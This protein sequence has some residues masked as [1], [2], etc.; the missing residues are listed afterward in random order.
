MDISIREQILQRMLTILEP[1]AT[2]NSATLHRS[3]TV[4]LTREQ[5]P[6]LVLFPEAETVVQKANDRLVRELTVKIVALARAVPPQAPETLAD[7]LMT[8]AHRALF[9]DRNLGGLILSL[10][11]ESCDWDVEDADAI[12]AAIPVTYRLTY[13]THQHDIAL[14]G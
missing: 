7:Q 8:Q 2:A 4:A 6:A 14:Q 3:P 10:Q 13:R 12:A 9:A 11:E 5:C 1:I